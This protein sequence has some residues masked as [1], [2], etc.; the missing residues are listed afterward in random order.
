MPSATARVSGMAIQPLKPTLSRN[1]AITKAMAVAMTINTL[2]SSLSE[3]NSPI[4]LAVVLSE[5]ARRRKDMGSKG[6]GSKGLESCGL[7]GMD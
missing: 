4:G 7:H 6:F 5:L 1:H 2:S 3:E